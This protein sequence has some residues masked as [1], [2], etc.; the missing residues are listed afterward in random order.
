MCRSTN[1][2]IRE[3]EENATQ[4]YFKQLYTQVTGQQFDGST[5]WMEAYYDLFLN[6]PTVPILV[7]GRSH[8]GF[9]KP[10]QPSSPSP[11]RLSLFFKVV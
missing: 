8:I 2:L 6:N 11:Q 1:T 7:K 10:A 4:D 9:T 5:P 3:I